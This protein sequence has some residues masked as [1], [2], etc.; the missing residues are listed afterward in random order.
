LDQEGKLTTQIKKGKHVFT[1]NELIDYG[2][3]NFGP[4]PYDLVSS[5]L[6]ACTVMT[7]QMYA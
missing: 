4:T 1:A 3:N 7:L 2:K 5:G 6:A